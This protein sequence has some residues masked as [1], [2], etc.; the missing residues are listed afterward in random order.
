MTKVLAWLRVNWKTVLVASIMALAAAVAGHLVRPR[1]VVKTETKTVQV[2]H[3][4]VHTV[5][6]EK[7]VVTY[8]TRTVTRTVYVPGTTSVAS[9]TVAKEDSGSQ[10]QGTVTQSSSVETTK[11]EATAMSSSSPAPEGR[12]S[13]RVMAGLSTS[14]GTV[15]GAGAD[16]RLIGP[17]TLGLWATTTLGA[18]SA[19]GGV[20]VGL[21][22]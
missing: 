16:Y 12:W 5:I 13:V 3:V 6:V 10:S 19:Q 22:L 14:T 17:L 1:V 7:P 11:K 15:V 20:A 21:R 4:V 9:V 2:D 8:R 18:P